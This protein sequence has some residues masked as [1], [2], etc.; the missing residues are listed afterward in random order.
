MFYCKF[1]DI[2]KSDCYYI[3][4]LTLMFTVKKLLRCVL[5]AVFLE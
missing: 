3:E 4:I 5:F 2:P 1:T